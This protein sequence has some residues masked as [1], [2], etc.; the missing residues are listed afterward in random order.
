MESSNS[1][2]IFVDEQINSSNNYSNSSADSQSQSKTNV[3]SVK[4][5]LSES[6]MKA[7]FTAV[8]K[9]WKSLPVN[10]RKNL[11]ISFNGEFL[12]TDFVPPTSLH[13]FSLPQTSQSL[14][15]IALLPPSST[16][17]VIDSSRPATNYK[18]TYCYK[19]NPLDGWNFC[20]DVNID[21]DGPTPQDTSNANQINGQTTVYYQPPNY[22]VIRNTK[23]L[24]DYIR[25]NILPYKTRKYIDFGS[26]FCVC[27]AP[28]DLDR[29]YIECSYGLTGCFGWVG[30][31]FITFSIMTSILVYLI[32]YH[33]TYKS[34]SLLNFRSTPSVSVSVL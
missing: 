29:N 8:L 34:T 20:I 9:F 1:T 5:I 10:P 12:S 31:I 11:M 24:E 27:H 6:D 13:P 32:F 21:P 7:G 23:A 30:T 22:P 17:N 14:L 4:E 26:V 15:S 19:N 33:F 3:D 16:Q 25:S 2:D 28:E 18:P